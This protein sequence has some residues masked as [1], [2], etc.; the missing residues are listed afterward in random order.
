MNMS[1]EKKG[2]FFAFFSNP[3]FFI[4]L[5]VCLIGIV[6][7]NHN[8]TV[9]LKKKFEELQSSCTSAKRPQRPKPDR[10]LSDAEILKANGVEGLLATAISDVVEQKLEDTLDCAP[11]DHECTLKPGPKG[12]KGEQGP[13]GERGE[14]GEKGDRGDIGPQGGKGELGHTGYKGEKG[15]VG[16]KGDQGVAGP[17]GV[18]GV[19]GEQGTVALRQV[20]CDWIY[21]DTCG[22]QC[23]TGK[24][25]TATCPVGKY[26]A[27]FG[28]HT[29]DSHGRYNT[30]IYCCLPN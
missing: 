9:Q 25:Y 23:G 10:R 29:W 28:I 24:P 19:K 18:Q 20:N 11:D 1:A 16:A 22:H 21:T 4:F 8:E 14:R 30:R 5:I 15:E 13:R 3:L 26:V 17:T 2:G 12:D 7:H 27:G 6:L